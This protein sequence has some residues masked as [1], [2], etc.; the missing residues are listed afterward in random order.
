MI[1]EAAVKVV[2]GANLLVVKATPATQDAVATD[3][4]GMR[5]SRRR[6]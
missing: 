1:T 3:L 6:S 5:R 4:M 2:A